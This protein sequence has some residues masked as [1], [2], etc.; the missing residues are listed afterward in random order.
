MRSSSWETHSSDTHQHECASGEYHEHDLVAYDS[1]FDMIT[2]TGDV[3]EELSSALLI[4]SAILQFGSPCN[5]FP[6]SL[7]GVDWSPFVALRV[8]I[9]SVEQRQNIVLCFCPP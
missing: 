3:D 6:Y 2:D 1:D 8:I 4:H 9:V 5:W 7:L